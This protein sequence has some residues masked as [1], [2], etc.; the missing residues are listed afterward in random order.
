MNISDLGRALVQAQNN[1]LARQNVGIT[2][3]E[4]PPD[5]PEMNDIWIYIS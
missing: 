4:I 3:S 5:N 2:V 1:D